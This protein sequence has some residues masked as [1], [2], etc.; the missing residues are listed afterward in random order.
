MNFME[1][2]HK[3]RSVYALGS[4]PPL[5]DSAV[6]A[7]V[8][9]AMLDAPTAFHSQSARVV[10]LFE[11]AHK[12]FWGLVGDALRAIVP[13][14]SFAST[15]EKLAGFSAG[16]GT[17]LFYEDWDVVERM[18]KEYSVFAD[19]FPI[20]SNQG[21]AILQYILWTAL[22]A[23]NV[24]ASLQHYNPIVDAAAAKEFGI[25]P[26]WRLNAQM[27][28]GSIEAPTDEKE[29]DSLDHRLRIVR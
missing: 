14:G 2:V 11:G 20:W 21:S 8:K 23:E 27:P 18:Q 19:K 22:A 5:E 25:A 9:A 1:Y 12:K 7:L 15:A 28:F 6:E 13:E 4:K 26:S 10:L 3:R 17:I 24:G 29:C 16:R